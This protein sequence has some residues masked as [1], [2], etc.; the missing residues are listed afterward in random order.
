MAPV[1]PKVFA[2]LF[3]NVNQ[4]GITIA[5][6]FYHFVANSAKGRYDLV[7]LIRELQKDKMNGPEWIKVAND[8]GRVKRTVRIM[9]RFCA[10]FPSEKPSDV[11]ELLQWQSKVWQ[12][13]KSAESQLRSE[14]YPGDPTKK[15]FPTVLTTA[16]ALARIK[17]LERERSFPDSMPVDFKLW[18]TAGSVSKKTDSKKR[19]RSGNNRQT[20]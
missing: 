17:Q 6:Q 14:L 3:P 10:V 8:F 18:L 13:A 12:L 15:M 4:K 7:K 20:N 5:P 16:A 1:L 9:L 2:F 11:E 19:K